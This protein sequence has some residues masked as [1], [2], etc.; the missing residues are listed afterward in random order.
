MVHFEA[1][2]FDITKLALFSSPYF[3]SFEFVTVKIFHKFQT[4][5]I[6]T[7]AFYVSKKAADFAWA[8]D[9]YLP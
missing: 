9:M 4:S 7:S 8:T 5:P 1:F 3:F 6:M 2:G